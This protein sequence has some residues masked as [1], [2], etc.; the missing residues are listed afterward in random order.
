MRCRPQL[1]LHPRPGF[2]AQGA[3]PPRTPIACTCRSNNAWSACRGTFRL[4]A[5]A[6]EWTLDHADDVF[7]QGVVFTSALLMADLV[8]FAQV[9]DANRN[10]T[11]QTTSAN[12]L[13][14]RWKVYAPPTKNTEPIRIDKVIE[15]QGKLPV[16][17]SAHRK[18]SIT[19][20]IGFSA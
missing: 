17:S 16:P 1:T 12:R 6:R 11:H 13:S 20:A 9:F 19:P 15:N 5:V 8:G 14:T 2:P 18:P 7:L 4:L 10:V 3:R